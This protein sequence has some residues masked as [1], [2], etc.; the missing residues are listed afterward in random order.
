MARRVGAYHTPR[1]VVQSPCGLSGQQQGRCEAQSEDTGS[2]ERH[3]ISSG[4]HE[5]CED[6]RDLGDP[7]GDALAV[8]LRHPRE[9]P[10]KLVAVQERDGGNR[11]RN[12]RRDESRET[13]TNG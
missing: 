10:G 9:I 3:V 2:F 8:L 12:F 4:L 13:A 5:L 1:L 6:A 7:G 11:Q